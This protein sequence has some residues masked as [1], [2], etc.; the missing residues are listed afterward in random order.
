MTTRPHRRKERK[1]Q[2]EE[3]CD[4]RSLY[5]RSAKSD[6]HDILS[7]YR[8]FVADSERSFIRLWE[9]F[10]A[11]ICFTSFNGRNAKTMHGFRLSVVLAFAYLLLAGCKNNRDRETFLIS[12]PAAAYRVQMDSICTDSFSISSFTAKE[13]NGKPISTWKL[14]YPVFRFLSADVDGDGTKDILVGV[15][16]P[17]RFD[18]VSRKRIFIFKLLD[19]HIRP[20]WLGSRV[21]RPLQDFN[22]I[23]IGGVAVIR[24]I[25]LEQNGKYLVAE[26]KWQGFGLTFSKYIARNID[27]YKARRWLADT[28]Q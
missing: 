23:P 20:L 19:G 28:N 21:S 24:T 5:F 12:T 22:T 9:I 3:R 11:T 14:N 4:F 17:T 26:Y 13:E 25:E 15:I 1:K 2:S 8:P 27:L 6:A 16:K 18:S 7:V 10:S